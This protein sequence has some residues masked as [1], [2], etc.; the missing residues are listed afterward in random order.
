MSGQNASMLS[1]RVIVL[2]SRR[3]VDISRRSETWVVVW[4][5]NS[6]HFRAQICRSRVSAAQKKR[7]LAKA[8]RVSENR[9]TYFGCFERPN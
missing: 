2:R 5:H 4:G 8:A 7:A 9:H 3:T 6:Q 1:L